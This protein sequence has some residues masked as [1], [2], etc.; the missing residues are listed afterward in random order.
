[1]PENLQ[2]VQGIEEAWKLLQKTGK[3]MLARQKQEKNQPGH[4]NVKSLNKPRMNQ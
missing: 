1:L 4:M 3:E 2:E